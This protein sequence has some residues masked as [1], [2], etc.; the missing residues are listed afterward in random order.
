MSKK[1]STGKKRQ[2]GE[3]VSR[4]HIKPP[5]VEGWSA[6][7]AAVSA[8][9]KI[10]M[11]RDFVQH[12]LF[13]QG[14][15]T[16]GDGREITA[17]KIIVNPGTTPNKVVK[18]A[19]EWVKTEVENNPIYAAAP[20]ITWYTPGSLVPATLLDF[21]VTHPHLRNSCGLHLFPGMVDSNLEMVRGAE[22]VQYARQLEKCF[23]YALLS[24]YG[25]DMITGIV[26]FFFDD[27][28]ELQKAIALSEA[29]HKFLF[30][31]PEKFKRE[32]SKAYSI[33]ELLQTSRT[34]TIYTVSSTK[35]DVIEK[36]FGNLADSLLDKDKNSGTYCK[37]LRL[38]IVDK[39]INIPVSGELKNE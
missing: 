15:K 13:V 21:R 34:V 20:H 23:T 10:R 29:E 37:T 2:H 12:D 36:Q 14:N 11:A 8:E 38:V 18:Q 35:D 4:D 33:R 3:K 26:F 17:A 31:E 24:A 30:L 28:V 5:I 22:A 9:E 25:F 1:N 39:E 27:E 6:R 32:G 16:P 19:L 7:R